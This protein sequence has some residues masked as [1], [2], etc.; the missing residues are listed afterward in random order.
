MTFAGRGDQDSAMDRKMKRGKRAPLS[1]LAGYSLAVG[2]TALSALVRWLLP[3]ALA[4]APYLGFY[5]AV[6]ISAALGGVGPGLLSTFA[7]L[8]LVNFVF[9]HFN[10]QDHGS[11][12]RQVIWVVASVGVS[13]LAGM[14]RSARLRELSHREELISINEELAESEKRYRLAQQAAGIGVFEWNVQSNVNRWSPE[15]EAMYGLETGSF[16]KTQPAWEQLVHPEDRQAAVA[17][18]EQAFASSEPVAGE[19]RIVRP[20]GVTRWI[21]GRFQVFNDAAGK[22]LQLSGV[23][24]DITEQKEA[25]AALAERSALLESVNITMRQSRSAALS[26]MEDAVIA[27]RRTEEVSAQLKRTAERLDLLAGTA[28]ELLASDSPQEIVE[29]LCRKVMEFLDCHCFFNFLVNEET[30]CLRLNACAGIPEEEREKIEWLDYGVAVCGC[31]ARDACR[32]VAEDIFHTVDPRTELVESYGIQAYACHPLMSHGGL[33]G[34]LSFGTRS[35][36][37]FSE[38]DLALMKAVTDQ[39]AIAMERKQAEG[40][41]VKAKEKADAATRA[42]S[43]FLANMSHELRTPMTGVIGMLDLVLMEEVPPGQRDCIVT[44]HKAAHSLVRILNDILDMTKIE[45]GKLLFEEKPF[46]LRNCVKETFDVLLPAARSKGIL[47]STRVADD[48]PDV[49][50]GDQTRISQVLTNLAGNAVK[51]TAKGK[52]EIKVAAASAASGAPYLVSFSITD[53]G[54]GIPEAKQHLLFREFSQVDE[55]HSRRYGGTGL[56]LAI[57][58]EIVERMGGT[59]RFTSEEGRGSTFTFTVP[60]NAARIVPKER[61]EALGQQPVAPVTDLPGR[62]R[63]LLV[64]DDPTIGTTLLTMLRRYN[65]QVELAENGLKAVEMWEAGDYQLIL[66]DVQMPLLNGFE[67]TGIIRDKEGSTGGHIPIIA[68]TAHALQEDQQRCL[69]AG[70]DAYISK[71][72]DFAAS[73]KLIKETLSQPPS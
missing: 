48:L 38:E 32:I 12:M 60:L 46:S 43:Q 42:K 40:E 65:Y 34:T 52:V 25:A 71:P 22:A 31:V 73:L 70:M 26:M 8:L 4:P 10:V 2:A 14:Q 49:V 11:L 41:L 62:P 64:E 19:W 51:F 18:V 5:P 20:D 36:T 50:S 68:M 28:A 63:L 53:T 15:L 1:P 69:E 29:E 13:L 72:I 58:R 9:G 67:A 17:L 24:I 39:V 21:A 33:L 35:R 66:M 59:I 3:W 6:V 45:A 44:A 47:L 7:S 57:S 61:Q 23:N 37:A 55:S 16:G 54:I 56:G 27:Q 30:D